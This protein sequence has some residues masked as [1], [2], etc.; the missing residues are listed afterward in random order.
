MNITI[1]IRAARRRIEIGSFSATSCICGSGLGMRHVHPVDS[2]Y[3]VMCAVEASQ[4][5]AGIEVE[6][7]GLAL[8]E[9]VRDVSGHEFSL[10][11]WIERD[12]TLF[13]WMETATKESV[14]AAFETT[15]ARLKAGDRENG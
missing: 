14:L 13:H 2:T 5:A 6:F 12:E 11:E 4:L 8:C 7:H 15:L 1:I 10:T 3:C 9:F